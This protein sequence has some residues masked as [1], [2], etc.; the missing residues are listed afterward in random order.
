M[1]DNITGFSTN[2]ITHKIQQK[3]KSLNIY[4]NFFFITI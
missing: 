1:N 2:K 3:E 4:Q